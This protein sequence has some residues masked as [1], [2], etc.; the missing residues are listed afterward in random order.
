M[1]WLGCPPKFLNMVT[2]L[3]KDQYNQVRHNS[4]FSESFLITN[5]V[6][7]IQAQTLCYLFQHDAQTGHE[8]SR[9]WGQ[10][11]YKRYHLDVSLLNLQWLEAHIKILD[12][13]TWDL[14]F[15]IDAALIIAHTGQN[16]QPN[17]SKFT[18]VAQL[19]GLEVNLK[20]IEVQQE[21]CLLHITIGMNWVEGG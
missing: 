18:E 8:R 6:S 13:L 12:Q 20:K 5:C 10:S 1:E 21:Y 19:F 11:L 16:L 15:A 17:T 9:W 2:H 7:C 4:N 14:W 3:H